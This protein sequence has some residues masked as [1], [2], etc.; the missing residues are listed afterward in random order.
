M[1]Y[2]IGEIMFSRKSEI[3]E[4]C[5]EILS[6][7]VDGASVPTE[8]QEFLF[9]LFQFHDEWSQKSDGGVVDISTKT[10]EHG[11]RCFILL[12]SSQESIDI[13]FPHAIKLIPTSRS[14]NLTPQ[15]LIDFKSAARTAVKSQI[16]EFRGNNLSEAITCAVT[17]VVINRDNCAV[18]HVHPMTFDQL[19]LDFAISKNIN[20]LSVNVIS[21]NGVVA[22]FEDAELKLNWQEYHREHGEFTSFIQNW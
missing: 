1:P 2:T 19:L 8:D 6:S 10:T 17:N 22:E 11:T 14:G 7:T 18:D 13:S 16:T 15:K 9:E 4:K 3:T 21:T 5:R 12:K 20:P